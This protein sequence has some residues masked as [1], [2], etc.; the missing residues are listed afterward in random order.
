MSINIIPFLSSR[1]RLTESKCTKTENAD[2][3][4]ILKDPCLV[5]PMDQDRPIVD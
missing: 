1:K 4:Q 2:L 3:S 5:F